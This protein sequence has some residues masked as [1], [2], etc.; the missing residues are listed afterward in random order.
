VLKRAVF[1]WVSV[2]FLGVYAFRSEKM[3]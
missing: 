1:S 2:M 3:R